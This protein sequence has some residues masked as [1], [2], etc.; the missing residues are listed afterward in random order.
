MNVMKLTFLTIYQSQLPSH[1]DSFTHGSKQFGFHG[2][3]H[4]ELIVNRN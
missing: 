1:A 3:A 4:G 2:H